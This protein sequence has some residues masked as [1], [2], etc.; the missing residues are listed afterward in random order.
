MDDF[1]PPARREDFEIAIFCALQLEYDAVA[2]VFDHIYYDK[3]YGRVAGDANKYTTGR[4]GPHDVVLVLLAG[5]GTA[6][7]STASAQMNPSFTG[8]RLALLVGICAGIPKDNEH[9]DIFLGDVIISEYVVQYDLVRRLPDGDVYKDGMM[10]IIPPPSTNIR[11]LVHAFSTEFH[12]DRLHDATLENIEA[13]QRADGKGQYD[14]PGIELDK[15]FKPDFRHK[16]RLPWEECE[17]CNRCVSKTDHTCKAAL[18]LSCD[19]LHCADDGLIHRSPR[20]KQ[21]GERLVRDPWIHIGPIA[22]GNVVM[23]SGEDR[24]QV[25]KEHSAIAFEMEGAGMFSNIDTIIIKSVCDYADCHK[26]KR[27][28]KYAAATAACSMKGILHQYHKT[29][30][31][32]Q[33]QPVAARQLEW[34]GFTSMLPHALVGLLPEARNEKHNKH[35]H[36]LQQAAGYFTGRDDILAEMET[37]FF[38]HNAEGGQKRFVLY[39][40]G[41]SG[42]TQVSLK[43]AEKHREKFWGAFAVDA[44]SLF[45]LKHSFGRIA[46]L[47]NLKAHKA[48]GDHPSSS[49]ILAASLF[50]SHT[51]HSHG[52]L[53]DDASEKADLASELAA[54]VISWLSD[55]PDNWLMI[56][57]NADD[58][59]IG[60]VARFF[61]KSERGC[62]IVTTRNRNCRN[63]ATV[64]YKELAEMH[65]DESIRLFLKVAGEER[66]VE[67]DADYHPK[68]KQLVHTLGYLALAIVQA[69]AAISEERYTLDEYLTVYRENFKDLM[70]DPLDQGG[71]GYKYSVYTTWEVSRNIIKASGRE[72]S[73]LALEILDIAASLHFQDIPETIYLGTPSRRLPA[74]AQQT[75][76]PQAVPMSF[77]R[78][79]NLVSWF[80]NR[81]T[82]PTAATQSSRGSPRIR[83][84]L[85]CLKQ[86][87]VVEGRQQKPD[88]VRSALVLLN[89]LC[90]I[91]WNVGTKSFSMHS[92]VHKWT[93]DRLD[94][95]NR[96]W[97]RWAAAMGLVYAQGPGKAAM[98]SKTKRLVPSIAFYLYGRDSDEAIADY[99]TAD[100]SLVASKLAAVFLEN[101]RYHDAEELCRESLSGLERTPGRE[102]EMLAVADSLGVVLEKLCKYDEAL[103]MNRRAVDGRTKLLG[104]QNA[105]TLKSMSN[106]AFTL[107]GKADYEEAEKLNRVVLQKREELD[108]SEAESTIE[109][110][111]NLASNLTHQGRYSTAT[112]LITRALVWREKHLGREDANTIESLGHLAMALHYQA[113]PGLAVDKSREAL[114]RRMHAL[115]KEHPD[116]L[117]NMSQLA[118]ILLRRSKP[119][120]VEEAQKLTEEALE[121]M[122]VVLGPSNTDTLTVKTTLALVF[123]HRKEFA[124][125]EELYR[126][127]LQG[128][129]NQLPQEHPFILRTLQNLAKVLVKRKQYDEAEGLYQKAMAGFEKR[130]DTEHPD[131]LVCLT[132]MAMLFEDQNKLEDAEK[133]YRRTLA[134]FK[135]RLAPDHMST[136]KCLE[137]LASVLRDQGLF[138]EARQFGCQALKGYEA[139]LG[140]QDPKTLSCAAKLAYILQRQD[141]YCEAWALYERASS[142]FKAANVENKTCRKR[143][144]AFKQILQARG[145]LSE[146]GTGI[147]VAAEIPK[148]EPERVEKVEGKPDIKPANPTPDAP[149]FE[150]KTDA[151][152][153]DKQPFRPN[154]GRKRRHSSD[155]LRE[156]TKRARP[157]IAAS[158]S[159]TG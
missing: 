152:N 40:M 136:L 156:E 67:Q 62:I 94:E 155:L 21:I 14:Y 11:N 151:P 39:G 70:F 106:L 133:S 88:V 13:L 37:S 50:C 159:Y 92:L 125:A 154:I 8:I 57:D 105:M 10:D 98:L 5:M 24:D 69:G 150:E 26:N 128:F 75:V 66:L 135:R 153:E 144:D 77:M 53:R 1:I 86:Y 61:P 49:S 85:K 95:G 141:K 130:G 111:N 158:M 126:Q 43:F 79:F 116:T 42:K 108:G 51:G 71:E 2:K 119:G 34:T 118:V 29:D 16:H 107:E 140:P 99:L 68:A 45:T 72:E 58:P 12:R 137:S 84:A 3:D 129:E 83:R 102:D 131:A 132:N 27:F 22:S 157:A 17:V 4:I 91:T 55:F 87:P 31:P 104:M 7:S 82:Q 101:G 18:K 28:Q 44:T 46:E 36:L 120:D 117:T 30:R 148:R 93:R 89:K 73:V 60:D 65:P 97:S 35:Y 138:D 33:P 115:G 59:S 114:G 142:G 124:R 90:L 147:V 47:A 121:G 74:D 112:E 122:Q 64:G 123:Q 81:E 63:L 76:P 20:Q 127:A 41:G 100:Q 134:G 145:L 19:E 109:S 56:F 96:Q 48:E 110:V 78:I 52:D 143:F 80:S 6:N 32:K 103:E 113:E 23:K 15:L 139:K 25:A 149:T 54:E 9:N 38:S 146:D